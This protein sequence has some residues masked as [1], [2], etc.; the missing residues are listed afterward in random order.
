MVST[1]R[2][3]VTHT[4]PPSAACLSPAAAVT[5]C[6]RWPRT[7]V[8]VSKSHTFSS[9]FSFRVTNQRLSSQFVSL[10][11]ALHLRNSIKQKY[12][13]PK[14]FSTK[15]K[16]NRLTLTDTA[17]QSFA[18]DHWHYP[19]M[20]CMQCN[21]DCPQCIAH[22]DPVWSPALC[23]TNATVAHGNCAFCFVFCVIYN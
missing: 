7:I 11:T 16:I 20:E 1:C 14:L 2:L 3:A 18:R 17:N 22:H 19:A 21:C 4:A 23:T 12:A 10:A 13:Q 6:A 15:H 8:A 9:L 5:Q